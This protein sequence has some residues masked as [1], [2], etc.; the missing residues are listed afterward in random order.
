MEVPRAQI[1]HS[2]QRRNPLFGDSLKIDPKLQE[3]VRLIL[4]DLR[5]ASGASFEQSRY[6]VIAPLE[7]KGQLSAFVSDLVIFLDPS[8]FVLLDS[9]EEVLLILGGSLI[10]MQEIVWISVSTCHLEWVQQ[11]HGQCLNLIA[12]EQYQQAGVVAQNLP[13]PFKTAVCVQLMQPPAKKEALNAARELIFT[14]SENSQ[15]YCLCLLAFAEGNSLQALTL[16]KDLSD[17]A[18]ASICA[19]LFA[20]SKAEDAQKIMSMI[21]QDACKVFCLCVQL[22][23]QGN[24]DE[25]VLR[26]QEKL[27]DVYIPMLCGKLLNAG[28]LFEAMQLAKNV[29]DPKVVQV[30]CKAFLVAGSATSALQL[31]LMHPNRDLQF[32]ISQMLIQSGHEKEAIELS[33]HLPFSQKLALFQVLLEKKSDQSLQ[34]MSKIFQDPVQAK[35]LLQMLME[36]GYVAEAKQC[37]RWIQDMN[38]VKELAWMVAAQNTKKCVSMSLNLSSDEEDFD[39]DGG[40]EEESEEDSSSEQEEEEQASE[41]E[42]GSLQ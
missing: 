39:D 15:P 42:E 34:F 26:A 20:Q 22:M 5:G 27:P 14:L 12:R 6:I 19:E 38:L 16:A 28:N 11:Q 10:G 23:A 3:A 7:L 18:K 13:E 9:M 21:S 4:I 29:Q 8:L 37:L 33:G 40:Q 2:E 36:K 24:I 30:L 17:A 25:A 32:S 31:A 41:Q 35:Q 1:S